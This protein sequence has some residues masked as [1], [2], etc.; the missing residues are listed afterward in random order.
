ML[1]VLIG[2]MFKIACA[3]VA[4]FGS[5]IMTINAQSRAQYRHKCGLCT[6]ME[7][8]TVELKKK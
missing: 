5:I 3:P 2:E 1:V 7:S 8:R 4:R 6:S